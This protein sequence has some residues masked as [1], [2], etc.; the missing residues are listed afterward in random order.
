[1]HYCTVLYHITFF[2]N[3]TYYYVITCV[4]K[5]LVIYMLGRYLKKEKEKKFLLFF[6]HLRCNQL[7]SVPVPEQENGGAVYH[8]EFNISFSLIERW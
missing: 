6:A 3:V 1:M 7:I 8:R 5:F 4:T 2:S